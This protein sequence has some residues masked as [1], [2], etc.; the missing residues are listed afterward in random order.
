MDDSVLIS[1]T[2]GVGVVVLI[3]GV[4]LFMSKSSGSIAADRLSGLTGGRPKSKDKA[5]DLSSGILRG[6]RPS[7]RG[8]SHGGHDLCP[9]PKISTCSMNRLTCVFR[10]IVS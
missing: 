9:K 1:I 10:S 5:D 3:G 2:I 8:A 6:P 4:G 7:T